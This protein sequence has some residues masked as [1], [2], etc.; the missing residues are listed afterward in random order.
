[1]SAPLP[2]ERPQ[3]PI[4]VFDIE[5]VPDVDLLCQTYDVPG[6]FEANLKSSR[7]WRDLSLAEAVLKANEIKFPAPVF[8][9]VVSICAVYVHPETYTI[10]D[11]FRRSVHIN[12]HSTQYEFRQQEK[13]IIQEFWNFSIKHKQVGQIWYDHLLGDGRLSDFMRKKLKPVPVTFCG[14]N[15]TGFDLPVIEMRSLKYLLQ[16]P[17]PEYAKETGYDSY[18]SKFAPDKTFDL[19]QFLAGAGGARPNLQSISRAMGLGGKMTGMDGSL[20]ASK[21]YDEGQVDLIEEYCAVDVLIT[22]GVLLAVQRFRGILP[23]ED[24]VA[25]RAHFEGF[26]LQEGKPKS[27]AELAHASRDF[28]SELS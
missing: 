3:A 1:L 4:L 21:F 10:M 24:F 5:T 27:Y 9:T 18:R 16:C 22:Y 25:A 28:F 14:F 11:G 8:Q 12:A 6:A 19:C 15:I 26:L 20:V 2:Q 23:K 17:I 13:Q 7:H